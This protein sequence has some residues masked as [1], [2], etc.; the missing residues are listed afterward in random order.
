VSG[1]FW[2]SDVKWAAIE[3][4]LLMVGA[5]WVVAGGQSSRDQRLVHGSA[6]AAT[7]VPYR[8]GTAPTSYTT[9]FSRWNRWSQR[10][11]WQHIFADLVACTA[12]SETTMRT[13]RIHTLCVQGQQQTIP[14]F[15]CGAILNPHPNR[16]V[17]RLSGRAATLS[18]QDRSR[19]RCRP[20][21]RSR[22]RAGAARPSG[23][24]AC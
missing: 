17:A 20:P 8:Q 19:T 3:P 10:G 4:Q 15:G 11:L 23:R 2:L 22:W 24:C 6:K 16:S 14:G 12:P 13:T 7:G 1:P 21:P 5:P 18:M 9:V